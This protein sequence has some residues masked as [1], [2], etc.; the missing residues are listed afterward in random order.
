MPELRSRVPVT[1]AVGALIAISYMAMFVHRP[2]TVLRDTR[3]VHPWSPSLLLERHAWLWTDDVGLGGI[4]AISTPV[5]SLIAGMGEWWGF[6]P[7]V[8]QR[9]WLGTALAVGAV[10][11]ALLARELLRCT[12]LAAF[13]A[14]LWVLAAPFTMN[15]LIPSWLFANAVIVP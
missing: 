8:S 13:I 9:L 1:W 6:E 12:W 2:G 7:W 5:S 15:F 10:G 11:T 3:L 4:T 14:G